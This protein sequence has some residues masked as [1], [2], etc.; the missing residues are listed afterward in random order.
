M[1]FGSS[2]RAALVACALGLSASFAA[3]PATAD[4]QVHTIAD[5][6]TLGKI[7]KRYHTTIEALCRANDMN[8]RDSLKLGQ[9][10]VVPERGD[11]DGEAARKWRLSHGRAER[12]GDSRA[13]TEQ[14]AE[15]AEQAPAETPAAKDPPAAT[16]KSE[17]LEAK[18]APPVSG[19][20]MRVMTL[21]GGGSAYFYEPIGP[22]RLSMKPVI[23]Y[24]HGK[25]GLARSDC[26]RWAPIVRRLGWLACPMG[27]VEH[28]AGRAWGGWPA[29]H[30]AAMHTIRGLRTKYGR[31]IQLWGNT[32]IGFSE[33]AFAAMNVGVREPRTFNRLLILA[34]KDAYWGGPGT[35]ALTIARSRL[36]RVYLITGEQD[37]VLEGTRKMRGLL[38]RAGVATR[39]TTPV[40]VGH[41]LAL[42]R[43]PELYRMALVWL[44]QGP[45]PSKQ[46]VA[47]L[48]QTP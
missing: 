33:G 43:K 13:G 16:E 28:G 31:R 1:R 2:L 38:S 19:D 9:E 7:A 8:R 12:D 37:G 17:A 42:E 47:Q 23:L 30:S 32:L 48:A 46:K 44:D 15:S 27:P 6:H 11:H 4:P 29:A 41:E 18:D 25:G 24:L 34:G 40:G 10:I 22:G 36:R 35:E 21:P 39:I 5:G 20:G 14:D 26:R 45:A 3:Q